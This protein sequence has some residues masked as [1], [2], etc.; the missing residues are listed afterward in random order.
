MCACR[1]QACG[2]SENR[3]SRLLCVDSIVDEDEICEIKHAS[4]R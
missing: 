1:R 2:E 4:E 3:S